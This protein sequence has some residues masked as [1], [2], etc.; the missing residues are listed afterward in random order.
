MPARTPAARGTP[1][2]NAATVCKER[3]AAMLSSGERE[4]Y[5]DDRPG[6]ND[7]ASPAASSRLRPTT[8][9]VYQLRYS[10]ALVA[11]TVPT[12]APRH[13][14]TSVTTITFATSLPAWRMLCQAI[15]GVREI[16]W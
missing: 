11:F 9:K 7:F 6:Y 10:T 4:W 13:T 8:P 2:T 12:Q 14:R 1:M 3:F 15:C 5:T 16:T